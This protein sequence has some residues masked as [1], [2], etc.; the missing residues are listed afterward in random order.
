LGN[1]ASRG[2]GRDKR[3]Q[4]DHHHVSSKAS[5]GGLRM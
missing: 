5:H 2:T 1:M 4:H 3:E